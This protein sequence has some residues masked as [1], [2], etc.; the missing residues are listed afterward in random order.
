MSE[1]TTV[2]DL[3][4]ER[5]VVVF[6]VK[7]SRVHLPGG[8]CPV[9]SRSDREGTRKPAG[10]LF[11]DTDICPECRGEPYRRGGEATLPTQTEVPSADD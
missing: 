9:L 5:E 3:D 2:G 4:P 10:V 1:P 7:R 11:A 8:E 6:G